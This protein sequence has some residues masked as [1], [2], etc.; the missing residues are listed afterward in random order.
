MEVPG[1]DG[2]SGIPLG[3]GV[4]ITPNADGSFDVV[5]LATS[6]AAPPRDERPRRTWEERGEAQ[7]SASPSGASDSVD[8]PHKCRVKGCKRKRAKAGF[9]TE[10]A[11][12]AHILSEHPGSA[13]A[14]RLRGAG[15]QKT[16]GKKEAHRVKASKTDPGPRPVPAATAPSSRPRGTASAAGRTA[17]A[18]C[19]PDRPSPP[20]RQTP[21]SPSRL[22]AKSPGAKPIPRPPD[23]PPDSS[24]DEDKDEDD[25]DDEDSSSSDE[26]EAPA[27]EAPAAEAPA[28]A[29]PP[30]ADPWVVVP[31][32]EPEEESVRVAPSEADEPQSTFADAA[33]TP[34]S[35]QETAPKSP[36]A[37]P[38]VD[39]VRDARA[40]ANSPT[41]PEETPQ[42]SASEFEEV[43][44]EVSEGEATPST[45]SPPPPVPSPPA[46]PHP[47]AAAAPDLPVPTSMTESF[48]A[49]ALRRAKERVAKIRSDDGRRRG[50][51][52]DAS[53][54]TP[55][56]DPSSSIPA[57]F[58]DA[59]EYAAYHRTLVLDD[60]ASAAAEAVSRRTPAS[61][62]TRWRVNVGHPPAGLR[63]IIAA[64]GHAVSL[65]LKRDRGEE[66]G[67]RGPVRSAAS[68][69]A[70]SA[71]EIVEIS[72][73]GSEKGTALGLVRTS[74]EDGEYLGVHILAS[75]LL[76]KP[77]LGRAG[78]L[79]AVRLGYSATTSRREFE[80]A[81]G[82]PPL[83]IA[84]LLAPIL[85]GEPF[86]RAWNVDGKTAVRGGGPIPGTNHRAEALPMATGSAPRNLPAVLDAIRAWTR[87]GRYNP[88]QARAV[89]RC[90]CP[91][92]LGSD[93]WETI[94]PCA[95]IALLHGPPGTGKTRTLVGA[96]S[97]LLL[98]EPRPR[99]L[100]CA[101]SNAA[102]DEL[103]LRLAAGRVD[104]SGETVGMRPGEL[105]RVG[106][107]DQVNPRAHFLSLDTLVDAN[108]LSLAKRGDG[109][110]RRDAETRERAGLLHTARVVVATVAAAGAEFLLK[111]EFDAVVVDEAAQASEAATLV[112][113]MGRGGCV[114]RVILCGDHRQLPA[115]AHA[116]D[117]ASRRAYGVSLFERLRDGGA[118]PHPAVSLDEQHRMHP[119]IASFPSR[120]FYGGALRNAPDAPRESAFD[121]DK[122]VASGRLVVHL[123][124]FAFLHFAGAESRDDRGGSVRNRSEAR[125]VAAVVAAARRHALAGASVAVITPYAGQQREIVASLG[126]DASDV[127]VGTVDGFQGQE[128][129]VVV[130]SCVRTQNLGFLADERRLNVALTR[131]R[132]ALL[133]VGDAD[134]LRKK[135]GAWRALV[136]DAERRGRLHDIVEAD[137]EQRDGRVVR[138]RRRE[139]AAEDSSIEAQLELAKGS[140]SASGTRTGTATAKRPRVGAS[141]LA[142]AVKTLSESAEAEA[143]ADAASKAPAPKPAARRFAP[144]VANERKKPPERR[145]SPPRMDPR[146]RKRVRLETDRR[147][148]L[149]RELAAER[150]RHRRELEALKRRHR[151]Q[152]EAERRRERDL[153]DGLER[154]R[155]FVSSQSPRGR[156]EHRGTSSLSPRRRARVLSPTPR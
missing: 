145:A 28:A 105:L 85:T 53:T 75:D 90:V 79:A 117:E 101:P 88:S 12:V 127:R 153:R 18:S 103:A 130:L 47:F 129:D 113:L 17:S 104:R 43:P 146:E 41:P 141:R 70:P 57:G 51:A 38:V 139:T 68:P 40:G 93:G 35:F 126:G 92:D 110:V 80:A 23:S 10:R 30:N 32:D 136:E 115:T 148:R 107:I 4:R 25:D 125:A 26:A 1:R 133:V 123:S 56:R 6:P 27:A 135:K 69:T 7:A 131:A 78:A 44:E 109:T 89:R 149:E 52:N 76:E 155:R 14:T 3:P 5:S 73:A 64:G 112:P 49:L 81:H 15:W 120:H 8:R 152:L 65:A 144:K 96:V 20:R 119:E 98:C 34:V 97:A 13:A 102:A 106:P 86:Y 87:S 61:H 46:R 36:E 84:P 147:E 67:G 142:P 62:V 82:A 122:T 33:T 156:R 48:A 99:V 2:G 29:A 72:L 66:D 108:L 134:A 42:A 37:R 91:G 74:Q 128:A 9:M 154:E 58:S 140:A 77:G 63:A 121:E 111:F 116:A 94:R 118:R 50:A 39:E 24:T 11:L 21:L 19:E 138:Q 132:R 54:S 71:D 100:V 83:L 95:G 114:K 22:F 59:K 16:R 60:C 143:D 124:A 31:K 137:A 151:L 55:G 45:P 150:A